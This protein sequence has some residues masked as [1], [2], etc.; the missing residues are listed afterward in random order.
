MLTCE[1]ESRSSHPSSYPSRLDDADDIHYLRRNPPIAPSL[2]CLRPFLPVERGPRS[3]CESPIPA[4]GNFG[5]TPFGG[6]SVSSSNP[7]GGPF[8][9]R[10]N[11]FVTLSRVATSTPGDDVVVA[12]RVEG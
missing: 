11:R 4:S 5:R 1:P 6:I 8:S 9:A 10:L 3:A 12:Y 2:D 7:N